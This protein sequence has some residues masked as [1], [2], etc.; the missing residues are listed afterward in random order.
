SS[1]F[2]SLSSLKESIARCSNDITTDPLAANLDP[3][4]VKQLRIAEMVRVLLSVKQSTMTK[5]LFGNLLLGKQGTGRPGG[6]RNRG[7]HHAFLNEQESIPDGHNGR[8]VGNHQRA[9]RAAEG[10]RAASDGG[11]AAGSRCHLLP[12]A[13]E[14]SMADAAARLSPAGEG[15]FLLS[16]AGAGRESGGAPPRG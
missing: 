6:G 12:D 14:L 15:G 9:D 11:S 4:L 2:S 10:A 8:P 1:T 16:P 3:V 7:K 13:L 5:S